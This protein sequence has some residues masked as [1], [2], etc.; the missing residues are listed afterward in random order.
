[1]VGLTISE[2]E[3]LCADPSSAKT[4]ARSLEA[5]KYQENFFSEKR[6]PTREKKSSR[7][8]ANPKILETTVGPV[9]PSPIKDYEGSVARWSR[10]SPW[11]SL[12]MVSLFV[13]LVPLVADTPQGTATYGDISLAVSE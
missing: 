3:H 5:E 9:R 12:A 10:A 11:V 4:I 7:P 13:V 1:M 6:R 2:S 8:S